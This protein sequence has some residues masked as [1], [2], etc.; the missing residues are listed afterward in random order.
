MSRLALAVVS[1]G[2]SLALLG[3][4]VP[5]QAAP[6]EPAT[7]EQRAAPP[8]TAGAPD[9]R[10]T[11]PP[12][13]RR[14]GRWMVDPQGRVVIVHGLNLV[15]KHAPYVPPADASGFGERDADWFRRH[16]FNA[17]RLGPCGQA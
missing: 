15:Y 14:Q 9:A 17:A 2:L 7:T 1:G 11:E 8:A 16:G 4:V 12:Q 5:A 13:L 6:S 10:R 3:T